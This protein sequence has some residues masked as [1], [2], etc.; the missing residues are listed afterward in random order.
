MLRTGEEREKT[1]NSVKDAI[2]GAPIINQ[3]ARSRIPNLERTNLINT[4]KPLNS[5][6]DRLILLKIQDLRITLNLSRDM[7]PST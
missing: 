1:S 2:S 7:I 3:N 5:S 4:S 6:K